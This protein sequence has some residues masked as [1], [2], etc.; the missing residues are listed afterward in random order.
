MRLPVLLFLFLTSVIAK[1]QVLCG[2]AT[3]NSSVTLTAPAGFIFTVLDFASY[4]TPNGTC[5]AF[6]FGSCHSAS[7]ATVVANAFIGRTTASLGATNGLFGD[8][9]VGTVKRLYVQVQYSA[10]VPLTLQSFTARK[11]AAGNIILEWT[12]AGEINT[13]HFVVESSSDGRTF[14]ETG[15]VKATGTGSYSFTVK[16][17]ASPVYY[18]RLKMVDADGKLKF[19][20]IVRVNN[21]LSIV[22]TTAY[23]NPADRILTVINDKQQ[24]A[25]ITDIQ[26][27]RLKKIILVNGTQTIDIS[28]F[29]P[30]LYFLKSPTATVRF[31]KR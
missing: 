30:G 5:G 27:I 3:E 31:L 29:R 2:T 12:S 8:P 4:G 10:L 25:I 22:R 6:T 21:G 9:C 16:I 17:A 13:S 15:S 26:G 7:S 24:E 28:W 1:A 14:E 20:N 18:F 11:V 23:P 19:S